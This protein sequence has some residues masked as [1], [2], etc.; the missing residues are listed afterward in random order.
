MLEHL[1]FEM[2]EQGQTPTEALDLFGDFCR[3]LGV[4]GG[5][6]PIPT[7]AQ[8]LAFYFELFP[9]SWRQNFAMVLRDISN[10]SPSE[11]RF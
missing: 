3:F 9:K 7:V 8:K 4:V 2:I 5:D 6:T 10:G 1:K 11:V